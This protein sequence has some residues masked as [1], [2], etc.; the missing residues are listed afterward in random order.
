MQEIIFLNLYLANSGC[1]YF[2]AQ[3]VTR[4]W[5]M[6]ANTTGITRIIRY[7]TA[8]NFPVSGSWQSHDRRPP[9][10]ALPMLSDTPYIVY[11]KVKT[12]A[13]PPPE[14]SYLFYSVSLKSSRGIGGRSIPTSLIELS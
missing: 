8:K 2:P 7:D 5:L 4:G 12:C 6:F 10:A 1:S 3:I 9:S 11:Q 14:F 13:T